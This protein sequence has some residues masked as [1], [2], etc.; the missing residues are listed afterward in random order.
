MKSTGIVRKV[1]E[2]GRVVIPIELRRTLGIDKKDALEIYVDDEHIIL[3]K[4]EPACIFCD[5]AKDIQTYKG[6]N[7]C[8]ECLAELRKLSE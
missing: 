3:K 8:K 7:I 4:Y 5:N 6:K 1:D 2:L